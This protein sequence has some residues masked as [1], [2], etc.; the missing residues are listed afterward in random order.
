MFNQKEYMKKLF[1]DNPNLYKKRNARVLELHPDYYKEYHKKRLKENSEY[2]KELYIRTLELH[3]DY[4]KEQYI[5]RKNNPLMQEKH[6]LYMQEYNPKS[7]DKY[8]QIIKELKINGCSICGY[9]K[10][11]YSLCFHHVN[12]KDKKFEINRNKVKCTSV[13]NFV[14]EFHKCILLCVNCHGEITRLEIK[15]KNM[16]E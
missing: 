10:C 4:C 15:N 1:E 8:S 6:I 12:R 13:E 9:D 14:E 11:D 7:Y 2:P 16:E 3:P 5:K